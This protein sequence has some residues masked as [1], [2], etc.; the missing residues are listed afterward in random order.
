MNVGV[1]MEAID[2]IGEVY[3]WL[4]VKTGVWGM[5]I[6]EIPKTCFISR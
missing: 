4:G 5:E 1:G 6:G 3:G 2:E